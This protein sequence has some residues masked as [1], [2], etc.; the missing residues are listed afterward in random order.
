VCAAPGGSAAR[1]PRPI[2]SCR[3]LPARSTSP[4]VPAPSAGHQCDPAPARDRQ[5]RPQQA[6]DQPDH[7]MP[8]WHAWDSSNRT[9]HPDYI[10]PKGA[11][12][13]VLVM[14]SSSRVAPTGGA[15]HP[16]GCVYEHG[17]AP[18]TDV[19]ARHSPS[20]CRHMLS[21]NRAMLAGK[22]SNPPLALR[23]GLNGAWFVSALVWNLGAFGRNPV[24][25]VRWHETNDILA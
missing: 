19:N 16:P 8:R 18:E 11:E 15:A 13:A 22:K 12:R 1:P 20:G 7:R 9:C 21:T 10:S 4:T 5:T 17:A 23:P 3:S 2:W 25:L 24:A 14:R 6:A